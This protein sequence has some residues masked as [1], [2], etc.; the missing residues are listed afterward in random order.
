[1]AEVY[2]FEYYKVRQ[3]VKQQIRTKELVYEVYLSTVQFLHHYTET[4]H[5]HSFEYMTTDTSLREIFKDNEEAFWCIFT[6]IVKYWQLEVEEL[7]KNPAPLFEQFPTIGAVCLFIGEK[8]K[9]I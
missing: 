6:W 2:D 3:L 4:C 7:K 9:T 1:M 8:T 5:G